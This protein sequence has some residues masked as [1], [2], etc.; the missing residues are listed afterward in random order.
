MKY[1]VF[2]P[3]GYEEYDES[4]IIAVS[5]SKRCLAVR[6]NVGDR[7]IRN[8]L[9]GSYLPRKIF[10]NLCNSPYYSHDVITENEYLLELI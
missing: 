6:N 2:K 9:E 10:R 1:H 5:N 7:D 8:I 4:I 3:C